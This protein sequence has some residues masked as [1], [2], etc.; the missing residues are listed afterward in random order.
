M[1]GFWQYEELLI[2][3]SLVS[4]F[5][6][7]DITGKINWNL[8]LGERNILAKY[9]MAIKLFL[10]NAIQNHFPGK[11]LYLMSQKDYCTTI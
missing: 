7:R 2:Y 11:Q 3:L 6:S 8:Q 5:P 4:D 10:K 1:D 9:I